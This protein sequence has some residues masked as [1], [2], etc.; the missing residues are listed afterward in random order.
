MYHVHSHARRR[1]SGG[2]EEARAGIE[3]LSRDL[4]GCQS[5]AVHQPTLTGE[6]IG[7]HENAQAHRENL[8]CSSR[9]FANNSKRRY[10]LRLCEA[11]SFWICPFNCAISCCCSLIALSMVQRIGSL[12]TIK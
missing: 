8:R 11:C 2:S 12:L 1:A 10:R 3:A 4:Q 9:V 5:I 7:R 6:W